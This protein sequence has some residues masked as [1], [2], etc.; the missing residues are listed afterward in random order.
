V[1]GYPDLVSMV[2]DERFQ[3]GGTEKYRG[4][5]WFGH[6][7]SDINTESQWTLSDDENILVSSL[8][9]HDRFLLTTE[10]I[11]MQRMME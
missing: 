10:A 7:F 1:D 11:G 9:V 5:K 4:T 3:D 8:Y 2:V 6:D